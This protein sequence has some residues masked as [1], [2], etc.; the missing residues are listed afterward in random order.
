MTAL[1]RYA[2]RLSGPLLD[3]IDLICRVE[4]IPPATLVGDR[5]RAAE[6]SAA[7]RER[8]I[9]AR[10]RQHRRLEGAD[11]LCNADMDAGLTR[12]MVPVGGRVV[13]RLLALP[14]PQLLSG[15]GFD[16]VLKVARTIADLDGRERLTSEDVDEALGYRVSAL[17]LMAA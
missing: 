14:E 7:V 10:A 16:R 5:A 3:R 15:R 2:R 6:A 17:D 9:A 12:R 4:P 1:G 11:A 8:V 13:A